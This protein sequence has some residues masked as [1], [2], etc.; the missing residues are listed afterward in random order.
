M[1]KRVVFPKLVKKA[2]LK[3]LKAWT[4]EYHRQDED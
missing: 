4:C 3:D 1:G 2:S